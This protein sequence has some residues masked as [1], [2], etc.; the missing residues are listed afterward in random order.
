MNG[1]MMR[2]STTS[3]TR[4]L[5]TMTTTTPTSTTGGTAMK[6]MEMDLVNGS[7]NMRTAMAMSGMRMM[8]HGSPMDPT[9]QHQPMWSP[10]T[11]RLPTPRQSTRSTTKA[12]AKAKEEMMDASTVE[13]S[14]ILPET[15]QWQ[16]ELAR[17]E[18]KEKAAESGDGGLPTKEKARE[19]SA[20]KASA[21]AMARRAEARTT[22]T[23]ERKP[24]TFEKAFRIT[25][26]RLHRLRTAPSSSR[27]R[28]SRMFQARRYQRSM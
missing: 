22:G 25:L 9:P 18:E 23:L 16:K 12:R 17:K 5:L 19:S 20:T 6:L 11:P 7:T 4:R 28:S 26:L 15:A 27:T 21:R 8:L 10:R 13:A 1:G 24:W 2:R 14:G 3:T